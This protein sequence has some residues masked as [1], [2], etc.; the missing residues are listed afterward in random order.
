MSKADTVREAITHLGV[1]LDQVIQAQS[2]LKAAHLDSL[3]GN[4]G[5]FATFTADEIYGHLVLLTAT[6]RCA[7]CHSCRALIIDHPREGCTEW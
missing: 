2:S 4:V 7:P 5:G 1:A 3:R 6:L